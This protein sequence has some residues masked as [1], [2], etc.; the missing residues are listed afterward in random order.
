MSFN[1]HFFER[2][3]FSL[4]S[5]IVIIA[6]CLGLEGALL[7]MFASIYNEVIQ[8]TNHQPLSELAI[9]GGIF[10]AIDPDANAN[11]LITF[12]LATFSV[13]TPIAIWSYILTNGIFSTSQD[14]FSHKPNRIIAGVAIFIVLILFGLEATALYTMIAKQDVQITSVFTQ[15]EP[16]SDLMAYLAENKAFAIGVS[17][18]L[19]IVNLVLALLTTI[20]FRSLKASQEQ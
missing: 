18:V 6:V 5:T 14:W 7:V 2:A 11:D 3:S 12:L 4:A 9:I 16:A 15:V 20:A 19:A 1:S 8:I 17:A 10:T 13:A